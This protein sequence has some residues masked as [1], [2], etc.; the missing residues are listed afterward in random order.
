MVKG[1]GFYVSLMVAH[2]VDTHSS[3]RLIIISAGKG[4]PFSKPSYR[5]FMLLSLKK[6]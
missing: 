3:S 4:W 5:V 2:S 6:S 1:A